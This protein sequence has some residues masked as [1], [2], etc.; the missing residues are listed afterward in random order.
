[1]ERQKEMSNYEYEQLKRFVR[2]L[3][4]LYGK[5]LDYEEYQGTA[6]LEYSIVRK[7]IREL[8]HPELWERAEKQIIKAVRE[9]R[10]ER[11]SKIHLESKM[12]MDQTLAESKEP[13][14]AVL[15]P[16]KGNFANAVCLW[17]DMK[18]LGYW[19]YKIL[20]SL[21]YGDEDEKI[22]KKLGVSP[23]N[24]FALKSKTCER[25]RKYMDGKD[26]G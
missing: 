18:R 24:Y 2:R 21:Y 26:D 13:V 16:A 15:F 7:E 22:I 10:R 6:F 20:K 12:S 11:N 5:G 23:E 3:Y 8:W 25:I 19:E 4:F 9:M 17:V 14:Y 1:M